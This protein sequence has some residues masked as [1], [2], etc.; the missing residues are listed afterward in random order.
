V[1]L[2]WLE[3]FVLLSSLFDDSHRGLVEVLASSV[4][5]MRGWRLVGSWRKIAVTRINLKPS[6][7][8]GMQQPHLRLTVPE[9]G[10]CESA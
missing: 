2:D 8:P 9:H 1:R 3:G 4:P 10:G 6:S 7:F 5:L